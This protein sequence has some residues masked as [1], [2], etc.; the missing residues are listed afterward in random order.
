MEL[1]I[2]VGG[3]SL[4][5]VFFKEN[6]KTPRRGLLRDGVLGWGCLYVNRA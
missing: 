4:T 5:K 6:K 2:I 3:A 1:P